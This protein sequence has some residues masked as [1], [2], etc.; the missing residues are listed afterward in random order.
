MEKDKQDILSSIYSDRGIS[1]Y[2]NKA[3]VCYLQE[4]G[5]EDKA[6]TYEDVCHFHLLTLKYLNNV[7]QILRIMVRML[8]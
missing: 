4:I 8:I 7:D 1:L 3:M 5:Y 2:H 6:L